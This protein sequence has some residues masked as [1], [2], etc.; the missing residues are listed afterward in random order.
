MCHIGLPVQQPDGAVGAG[1][2]LGGDW[3]PPAHR[4]HKTS[5]QPPWRRPG[6]EYPLRTNDVLVGTVAVPS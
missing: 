4:M 5:P 1:H 3:H 2:M 6:A